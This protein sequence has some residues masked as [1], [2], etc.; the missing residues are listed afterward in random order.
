VSSPIVAEPKG[1]G[2][3]YRGT[4]LDLFA[5]ATNWKRYWRKIVSPYIGGSVAEVGAGSGNNT[6]DLTKLKHDHWLC[7]EPD[8]T[9]AA[10]IERRRAEGTLPPS[11]RVH[12][13]YLADLN[14]TFDTILYIDVLE[15]IADDREEMAAATA[16]LTPSGHLIVLA[17]AHQA[18]FTPFDSAI[19]HY[20][21]YSRETLLKISPA[22][23]S[24]VRSMYVDSLGMILSFSN[25]MILQSASPS[26]SQI[27]LWDKC[28]IPISRVL[29]RAF[30]FNVG[31]S[32]LVVWQ[33]RPI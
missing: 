5:R 22:G 1:Q 29:D 3:A 13:G 16:R 18:L 11:I 20:R 8:M 19:G 32:V 27:A 14:R 10:Q 9:L 26:R 17:P 33:K 23:L 7:I 31:K 25:R 15:H 6:G 24:P 4:E 30:S 2:H 21:R 28:V 12:P